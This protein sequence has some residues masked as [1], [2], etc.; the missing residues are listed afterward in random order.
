[1]FSPR[2]RSS[3]PSHPGTATLRARAPAIVDGSK[4]AKAARFVKVYGDAR[5]VD[6]TNLARAQN[7]R[8]IG[9]MTSTARF[10]CPGPQ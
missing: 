1:M 3:T 10:P 8:A 5:T 6:E 2:A 9:T 7:P 4:K